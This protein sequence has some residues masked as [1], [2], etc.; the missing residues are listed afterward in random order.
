MHPAQSPTGK[1]N[2]K[3]QNVQKQ[4]DKQDF[5]L[6]L[7]TKSVDVDKNCLFEIGIL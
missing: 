7:S 4:F 5:S 2:F 3:Y 1:L 6:K